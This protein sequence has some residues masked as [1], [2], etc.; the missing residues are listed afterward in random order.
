MEGVSTGP[1]IGLAGAHHDFFKGSGLLRPPA[2]FRND[3]KVLRV[4]LSKFWVFEAKLDINYVSDWL[5]TLH[6]VTIRYVRPETPWE[7]VHYG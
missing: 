5:D 3:S 6:D 7:E 1:Q 4:I 2:V